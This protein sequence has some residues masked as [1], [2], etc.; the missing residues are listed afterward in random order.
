MQE[1]ET[2]SETVK[3]G[4]RSVGLRSAVM[5]GFFCVLLSALLSA[6]GRAGAFL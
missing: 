6:G 5:V 2:M 1:V 3:K 4:P